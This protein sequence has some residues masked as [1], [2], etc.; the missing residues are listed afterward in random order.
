[1]GRVLVHL[2]FH[3]RTRIRGAWAGGGLGDTGGGRRYLV[4]PAD[5]P[6]RRPRGGRQ[7]LGQRRRG[8]QRGRGGPGGLL[9]LLAKEVDPTLGG[10][11]RRRLRRCRGGV[12]RRGRRDRGAPDE[13]P[14]KAP[15]APGAHQQV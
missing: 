15:P 2:G 13:L 7:G 1:P 6:R 4:S 3:R 12:I 9:R 11:S 10:R 5:R 8:R 14:V